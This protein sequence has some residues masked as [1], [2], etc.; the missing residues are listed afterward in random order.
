MLILD[1]RY[2]LGRDTFSF[3]ILGFQL[4]QKYDA[5]MTCIS[6][7]GSDRCN[8]TIVDLFH[9]KNFLHKFDELTFFQ[10][11]IYNQ[12]LPPLENSVKFLIQSR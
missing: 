3:W 11:I 2:V 10:R 12:S 8:H 4:I 7:L 6:I 9:T 5:A 1:K